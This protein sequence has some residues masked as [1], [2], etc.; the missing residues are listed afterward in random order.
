MCGSSNY[1]L[2]FSRYLFARF[3]AGEK[4]KEFFTSF[5][6]KYGLAKIYKI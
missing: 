4:V 3:G 6:E 1:L 2:P 5:S